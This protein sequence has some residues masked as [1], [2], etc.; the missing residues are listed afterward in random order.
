MNSSQTHITP[1]LFVIL[2]HQALSSIKMRSQ[3]LVPLLTGVAAAQ[4][5][6]DFDAVFKAQPALKGLKPTVPVPINRAASASSVISRMNDVKPDATPTAKTTAYKSVKGKPKTTKKVTLPKLKTTQKPKTTKKVVA[7]KAKTTK[8]AGKPR[9]K[10]EQKA[11]NVKVIKKAKTTKKITKKAAKKPVKPV[12]KNARQVKKAK[13]GASCRPEKIQ[14]NYSS[15]PDTP[16][17]F[18]VDKLLGD[19][20][21]S[22]NPPAGYTKSF[23]NAFGSVT[24]DEYIGYYQLSSFSVKDCA[25]ICTD[26]GDSCQAF[27]IYYERNPTV[28]P[29]IKSCPN[30]K[31]ATS[32]RCALW[33]SKINA[34]QAVNIGQWRASFMT[35]VSGSNGYWKNPAPGLVSDFGPSQALA[36]F[37]N[38]ADRA[39]LSTTLITSSGYNPAACAQLCTQWNTNASATAK[40]SGASSFSPCNYFNSAILS[41]NGAKVSGTYC[42]L[43]SETDS[44]QYDTL[45][46]STTSSGVVYEVSSSYGYESLKP[47]NGSIAVS[48]S[49]A[50]S[51][52]STKT[53]TST[54]AAISTAVA[55]TS[56]VQTSSTP[57]A[58][59]APSSSRAVSSTPT[60]TPSTTVSKTTS[61]T[62]KVTTPPVMCPE[63]GKQASPP[64]GRTYEVHCAY[65]VVDNDVAEGQASDIVGCMALC[66]ATEGCDGA[67]YWPSD[68]MCYMKSL[69]DPDTEP[70]SISK[71]DFFFAVDGPYSW[72]SSSPSSTRSRTT[73]TSRRT[74][75]TTR[76]R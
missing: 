61:A 45:F 36:G 63:L 59:A 23:L 64:G 51:A 42:A 76:R 20:A 4:N 71:V 73:T 7:G 31:S 68:G 40:A 25:A 55:V 1:S 49:R 52:S 24:A 41:A 39:A 37:V 53:S 67:A 70:S 43:F 57:A 44:G 27:N 50:P 74:T 48:S 21:S 9:P 58:V 38:P 34:T 8:K 2:S 56:S 6:I 17:G 69:A 54:P 46:T 12:A 60:T 11:K 5:G 47:I 29:D 33:G 32:V 65:D 14:Y 3:F 19:T 30:P 26:V 62:P 66:D 75:T 22:V 72:P 10:A 35:V 15:D 16:T 13:R 18:L 28:D